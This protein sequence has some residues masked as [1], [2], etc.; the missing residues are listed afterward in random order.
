M[1]YFHHQMEEY[2]IKVHREEHQDSKH[3]PRYKNKTK[4][5]MSF[6]HNTLKFN[7]PH[8]LDNSFQQ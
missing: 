2:H 6:L 5:S 7:L 4:S 8:R 3:Q 1:R